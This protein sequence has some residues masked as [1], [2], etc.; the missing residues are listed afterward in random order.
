M[1]TPHDQSAHPKSYIPSYGDVRLLICFTD[2]SF[3][4][5]CMWRLAFLNLLTNPWTVTE[6]ALEEHAPRLNAT[7]DQKVWSFNPIYNSRVLEKSWACVDLGL[8]FHYSQHNEIIHFVRNDFEVTKSYMT[9][10][11]HQCVIRVSMFLFSLGVKTPSYSEL[12]YGCTVD[13]TSFESV[14]E[15][16]AYF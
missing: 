9:E 15:S 6:L 11:G 1:A 16:H 13:T 8:G 10:A 2:N 14:E 7:W 3:A 5:P 4:L 12:S